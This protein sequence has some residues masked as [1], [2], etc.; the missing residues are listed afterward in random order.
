MLAALLK[1]KSP[2][3]KQVCGW[4]ILIYPLKVFKTFKQVFY[5]MITQICGDRMMEIRSS[6]LKTEFANTVLSFCVHRALP[7]RAEV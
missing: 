7:Q 5:A 1:N 3:K 4:K 6:K 2:L